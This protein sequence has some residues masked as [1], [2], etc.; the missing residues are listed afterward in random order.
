MEVTDTNTKWTVAHGPRP[1][2]TVLTRL[3]LEAPAEAL[4]S[5]ICHKS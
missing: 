5:F 1:L 3:L 2:R 4:I